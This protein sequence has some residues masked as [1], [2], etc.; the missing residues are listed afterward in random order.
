MFEPIKKAG[1]V[2][3][4]AQKNSTPPISSMASQ[5]STPRRLTADEMC[6]QFVGD[7]LALIAEMR[8]CRKGNR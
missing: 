3:H 8:A 4:P 1:A 5:L 2:T 6:A 7:M